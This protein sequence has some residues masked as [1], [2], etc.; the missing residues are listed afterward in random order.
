MVEN[1][2][3]LKEIV[4]LWFNTFL[5]GTFFF[6]PRFCTDYFH[7]ALHRILAI[8]VNFYGDLLKLYKISIWKL[9]FTNIILNILYLPRLC[10][11]V[12]SQCDAESASYPMTLWISQ[13]WATLILSVLFIYLDYYSFPT[14][15]DQCRNSP[16]AIL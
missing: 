8:S 4:I 12:N 10:L 7:I 1:V 3:K 11:Y 14:G 13:V 2:K 9:Y 6:D 5:N 16:V 15:D